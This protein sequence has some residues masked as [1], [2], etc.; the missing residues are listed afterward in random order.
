MK[1]NT[2]QKKYKYSIPIRRFNIFEKKIWLFVKWPQKWNPYLTNTGD[3]CGRDRM[4]VR[5]TTTYRCNQCPSPLMLWFRISI[6]ARCTLCD[7][8]CQ[9]LATGRWC[10]PGPLVSSTNKTN[11]HDITE[12]LLKVALNSINQLNQLTNTY[13]SI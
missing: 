9:W 2:P 10:Y 4:V 11:H 8:V 6:R 5:F 7:K 13:Q 3:C 1:I 12:I